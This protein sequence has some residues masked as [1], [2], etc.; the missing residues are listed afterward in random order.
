MQANHAEKLIDAVGG[1]DEAIAIVFDSIE[2]KDNRF[3][4]WD[5][6]SKDYALIA[7]SATSIYT[8]DLE[9]ALKQLK[10]V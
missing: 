2:P 4:W 3:K 10:Y 7:T 6:E 1:K 5:V 8:P 9:K